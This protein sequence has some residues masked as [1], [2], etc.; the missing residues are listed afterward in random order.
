MFYIYVNQS[1]AVTC[2][3]MISAAIGDP[4]SEV[5]LINIGTESNH[6][7]RYAVSYREC[8]GIPSYESISP[9]DVNWF[10]GLPEEV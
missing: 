10:I 8:V 4:W 6:I 9:Y 2:N 1:D 5:W 7:Y 3:N